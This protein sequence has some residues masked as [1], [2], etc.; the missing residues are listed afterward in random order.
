MSVRACEP[1]RGDSHKEQFVD[2]VM[3]NSPE[4]EAI[5]QQMELVRCD[6]DED[7]QGIVEGARDMGDW[8]YYVKTYPWLCL[9]GAVVAGYLIVPVA[10]GAVASVAASASTG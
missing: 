8:R 1:Y 9:G 5:R 6:L 4:T 7:V 2:N 10:L 3:H